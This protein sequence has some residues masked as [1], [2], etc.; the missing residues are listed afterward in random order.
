MRSRGRP[1][2]SCSACRARR[3]KC[4][5]LKPSCTQCKRMN[6]QCGGYRDPLE[7][8]FRDESE[9][10]M[11]R[12]QRS[13]QATNRR[14]TQTKR[15]GAKRD[16]NDISLCTSTSTENKYETW[17]L[18]PVLWWQPSHP[19]EDFA[20]ANFMLCYVPGSHFDY[21]QSLYLQSASNGLLLA[22][23][24]AASIATFA[25]KVGRADLLNEARQTYAQALSETN[26]CLADPLSARK[27]TTLISV[28]L[29]GLFEAITWSGS[30][31]P[32]SW[33]MHTRG[34][35]ELLK[36]RGPQQLESTVGRNLFVQ[37]ANVIC[38][39]SLQR[40][41][42]VPP[43]ILE[44]VAVAARYESHSPKYHLAYLTGEVSRLLPDIDEAR[45]TAEEIVVATKKLDDQ[46]ADFGFGL[47]SASPFQVLNGQNPSP[48][49]YVLGAHS[50]ATPR[51]V[52]LWNSYRMTRILLNEILSCYA[53]DL[54]LDSAQ[55][56][57][58]QAANN[59]QQMAVDICASVSEAKMPEEHDRTPAWFLSSSPIV[60][61]EASVTSLL[62][63]LSVV[64]SA[65]LA[66]AEVRAFAMGQLKRL[67]R[68]CNIPQ[69]EKVA[70]DNNEISAL[71]DGLHMFYVS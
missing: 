10:V 29:L 51:A 58:T 5:R 7:Q 11:R 45:M 6:N 9:S 8:S 13:Y 21:L 38:V 39:N 68:N 37:V 67:G 52:Q 23:I 56:I 48:T 44:L 53:A 3:I 34:A 31:T 46:Y 65:D 30:S 50:Y 43:E 35:L 27:D 49:A 42:R 14:A 22:C 36:L 63:P 60:Q 70:M 16:D 32:V 61:A 62:W 59:I 54:Q 57:K 4:D 71:Q 19:T 20:V 17:T 41:T 33:D 47:M 12:A 15:V 40:K 24:R 2:A 64:K 69:A 55:A 1:S 18:K 66:S 26:A 25:R 28:L